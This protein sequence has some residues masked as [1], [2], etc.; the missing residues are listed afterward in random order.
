MSNLKHI[1]LVY[2]ESLKLKDVSD[3]S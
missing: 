1:K 3:Y 2:L